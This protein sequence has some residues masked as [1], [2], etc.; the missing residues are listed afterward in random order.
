[1]DKN[2]LKGTHTALI[3]PMLDGKVNFAD[4]ERHVERQIASGIN[5]LVPCG[6]TGES[7]TLSP[8]EHQRVVEVTVK[9]SAGRTPVIAGTGANSTA[10]A[11]HLTK[12]ADKAGA[13]AFLLVAPYYNK[14]SQEGLLAHFG[15]IAEITEKPIVLY[16]IPSRCGIE[17]STSTVA[18]LYEK[19]PHICAIK[20]AGGRSAKVSDTAVAL[21][22]DYVILSGDDALTLPFMACGASGVISVASNIYPAPVAK[23]VDLAEANDFDAARK[24]HLEYLRVF[25]ELFIEPNPVPA[26]FVMK[27]LGMI[28]SDEVRLPLCNLQP[29]NSERLAQLVK[30]FPLD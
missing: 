29:E 28:E 7:P 22:S 15:A 24:M 30:D 12:A 17:I 13:D 9:A 21:G 1:M 4:L 25:G 27:T 10:E 3:S 6:T 5:G 14:P 16:S 2:R 20:E 11:L 8:E 26:K 18:R 19:H 23:M